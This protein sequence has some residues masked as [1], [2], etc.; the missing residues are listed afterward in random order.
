MNG[1]MFSIKRR[2]SDGRVVASVKTRTQHDSTTRT[3]RGR[4]ALEE[5]SRRMVVGHSGASVGLG[6][7]V[8]VS[9]TET[10]KEIEKFQLR[11]GR[12]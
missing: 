1:F 8:D 12:L 10:I 9:A 7:V 3:L 6:D 5:Y 2:S 11:I 4:D